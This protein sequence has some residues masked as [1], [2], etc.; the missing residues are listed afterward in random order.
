MVSLDDTL[1]APN[2]DA[3]KCS[4]SLRFADSEDVPETVAESLSGARCS[5]VAVTIPLPVTTACSEV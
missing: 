2:T 4:D 1:A 3:W 5:V